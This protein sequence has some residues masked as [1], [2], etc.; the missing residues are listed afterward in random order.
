MIPSL[1]E[2]DGNIITNRERILQRCAEFYEKLCEDTVQNITEVKTEEVPLILTS[3]VERALS[4]MKSSKAPR[5]DHI[6]AEMIKAEPGA[7]KCS[8][9]NRNST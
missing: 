5:E 2:E 6:A 8:H 9:K 3:E 4:Q 7:F 1:K